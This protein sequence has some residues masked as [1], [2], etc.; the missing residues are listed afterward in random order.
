MNLDQGLLGRLLNFGRLDLRGTGVD[1]IHVPA[2][3]DSL[4]LRK[5]LQDGMAGAAQAAMPPGPTP[6]A[7]PAA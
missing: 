2:L 4:G 5:A 1:D 3:A 7:R 6:A